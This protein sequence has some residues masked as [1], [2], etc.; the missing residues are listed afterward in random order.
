MKVNFLGWYGRDNLGDEAF[1][2][3]HNELFPSVERVYTVDHLDKSADLVVL[4][5]GDVVKSFYLNKIPERVP[6][7]AFGVGMGYDSE[8]ELFKKKPP[9]H[10]YMRSHHDTN[11]ASDNGIKANFTPD[12]T[13]ILNPPGKGYPLP[14]RSQD[15]RK[16]MA[17]I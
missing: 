16:A 4:G 1:K 8:V 13:F 9:V 10:A 5:G 14:N 15:G 3:A 11:L 12:I 2:L 7:Y 17:V 6:Y